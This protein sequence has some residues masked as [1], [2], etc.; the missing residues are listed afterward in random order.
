[1]YIW[2]AKKFPNFSFDK[3]KIAPF[4]EQFTLALGQ[5]NGLIMGF[6]KETQNEIFSEIMLS[7]AL[8]TSEIEGEYFSREDVMSSL[9]ANIGAKEYH[10]SGKNKKADSIAHLLI[11]ARKEWN[12]PLTEKI[13]LNWHKILMEHEK[14]INAGQ[15]RKGTEAMQVI[16]GRF[17]E[18]EVH[19]EAPPSFEISKL[20]TDFI[21]WYH[22]FSEKELGKVGEAI[23]FS[24]LVHLY[25]ET[26]HPFEDGNGRIGRVLAEKSLAEKLGFP[27]T[28]S[29]SNSIEKNKKQYYE[30]LKA[31]QRNLKVTEWILYFVAI[32]QDALHES[33]KI[34]LFTI[35]KSHFFDQF[36]NQINE[37][38][39]KAILKMME[40]GYT[41]FKGGMTAKKYQSINK[42]SKATATRD[43]QHLTSIGAFT[44]HGGGRSVSYEL[45][46]EIDN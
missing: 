16:S 29:I 7:E 40:Q 35:K 23:V 27:I 46:L 11:E 15:Y 45:N 39:H 25:F 28:V 4:I 2:Q 12:K 3:N 32:L 26:L 22:N 21:E 6:T 43:L 33:Q 41:G 42:T 5:S 14:G 44:S 37:R 1:M 8:K 10:K 19:Y 20:M 13:I 31:A 18:I 24:A 30:A 17:G 36:K 9:Q 38:E 34:I